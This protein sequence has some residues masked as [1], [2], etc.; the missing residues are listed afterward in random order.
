MVFKNVPLKTD[1]P[2]SQTHTPLPLSSG[3]IGEERKKNRLIVFFFFLIKTKSTD[4]IH[5]AFTSVAL[6]M[7]SMLTKIKNKNVQNIISL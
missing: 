5:C 6:L 1:Y 3:L 4:S 2:K 7:R